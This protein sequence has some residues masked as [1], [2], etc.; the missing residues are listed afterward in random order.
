[1]SRSHKRGVLPR[2]VG[3]Y[4]YGKEEWEMASVCG[5]HKSEQSLPQRSLLDTSDRLVGGCNN[6]SPSDELFICLSRVPSDTISSGRLGEDCFCY[7]HWELPLQS[8]A[9]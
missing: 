5:F 1:M 6:S 2:M 3:Q 9:L 4:S 8:D 7:T